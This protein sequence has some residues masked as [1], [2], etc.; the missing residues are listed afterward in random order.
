MWKNDQ[1]AQLI[2]NYMK[3]VFLLII[4]LTFFNNMATCTADVAQV[5]D[6]I[7]VWGSGWANLTYIETQ[8][9]N[10]S[11]LTHA[12]TVFL[13]G[14]NIYVNG[15]STILYINDSD[16]TWL[17]LNCTSGDVSNFRVDGYFEMNSSKIT[18]WD[19]TISAVVDHTSTTM[20]VPR[21]VIR[22]GDETHNCHVNI[23][24]S[25]ISYCGYNLS[26]STWGVYF[27]Q[28]MDGTIE[29]TILS[30]LYSICFRR[31]DNNIIN[32][33]KIYNNSFYGLYIDDY[34]DNDIIKNCEI[35]NNNYLAKLEYVYGGGGIH[36][37]GQPNNDLVF[38][39]I[40]LHDGYGG[41]FCLQSGERNII[42]NSKMYNFTVGGSYVRG[43]ELNGVKNSTV[44]NNTVYN[45]GAYALYDVYDNCNIFKNNTVYNS[46][47]GIRIYHNEDISVG[48]VYE[49]I[50]YDN[51]YHFSF[52]HSTTY[53]SV[54]DNNTISGTANDQDIYVY[55][56]TKCTLQDTNNYDNDLYIR[57]RHAAGSLFINYTNNKIM[58]N[59]T[60]TNPQNINHKY[61]TDHSSIFLNN[62]IDNT[63]VYVYLYNGTLTAQTT[64]VT[65]LSVNE[66]NETLGY[67][68]YNVT[69]DS[70]NA[71][72]ICT[73]TADVAN[74]TDNY[75]CY[76][77]G[78]WVK[79]VIAV[80]GVASWTY[81]GGFSEHD[82]KIKWN[83]TYLPSSSPVITL[84]SQT[85][86]SIYQNMTCDL[87]ISFGI[88]HD[89]AG[90]NNTSV[91]FIFRNYDHTLNDA[92]H[93]IRVPANNK[94]APW[95]YD[96]QI[97]RGNN[98]NESLNFENN[99][100]I[101]GGNIYSWSGLDENSTRLT[102][103]PINSTYTIVN[104]NGTVHDLAMEQMWYLDR[105]SMIE[106][107]KTK[108]AIHKNQDVL[109][110]FWDAE[111]FKGNY[112]FIGAGYTD[113]SLG[114]SI[115]TD[116][117]PIQYYKLNSSYDPLGGT[118]PLDS[119]YIVY[120]GALNASGWVDHVYSP[121]PNTNYVRGMIN[122]SYIHT[123][124]NT[125]EIE[126]LYFTSNTPSSKPYYINI[127]N[128]V[129]GTNRTFAE[130]NVLWIG[131]SAPYTPHPYTPNCWFAFIYNNTSFD[132]KL[133]AADNND[134]WGNSSLE[135]N[136]IE[137]GLF[138]PTTPDIDHFFF[139][140]IKIYTIN[141]T[142]YGIF[143][144]VCAL[145]S[146]PDGG[147]VNHN[148]TLH[149]ANQTFVS[150]INNTFVNGDTFTNVSFDSSSYYSD[151]EKYQMRIRATDNEGEISESWT[152]CNFSLN[153]IT[154]SPINLRQTHT[155]YW[156]NWTW[157]EGT[158]GNYNVDSYNVSINGS[159]H[160][161]TTAL[162]YNHTDLNLTE[163]STIIIYGFND[164]SNLSINY[165]SGIYTFEDRVDNPPIALSLY[166][167]IIV[168]GLIFTGMTFVTNID[169][170]I[171]AAT[172]LIAGIIFI[173][174]GTTMFTTDI[175]TYHNANTY[176]VN[177]GWIGT[178]LI[179]I[180]AVMCL[181]TILI[182]YQIFASEKIDFDYKG[183]G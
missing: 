177:I 172:S 65:I 151:T 134:S 96:G 129:S 23:S 92:N 138:P 136:M 173:L 169:H 69:V 146:D 176:L 162:Y 181:F 74:I 179:L 141:G 161:I 112:N 20:H 71:T 94:C 5:G 98:R 154:N 110:K 107:T 153:I 163:N 104:I 103:V 126:Y 149:Y 108:L 85:P 14:A 62:T 90:L 9:S 36:T 155:D 88:S 47:F 102:I 54:V 143:D 78:T 60:P 15:T 55:D 157:D 87:N 118:A 99:D 79:N 77:D 68:S 28:W 158:D 182:I 117:H 39:N 16:C 83:S 152:C 34:N 130:T 115:P 76:V 124:M 86:S 175:N 64:N 80:A 150:I 26:E 24:K 140:N 168:V 144:V 32:Y 128:A 46:G 7:Y 72:E 147:N 1:P 18:S 29:D 30:Y 120:M 43:L 57:L 67:E 81:A 41:A 156:V 49:N 114:A 121:S 111:I 73:F 51:D 11:A 125:T 170:V 12:G 63:Y 22:F 180:G 21:S 100:T 45:I 164:S 82:L 31:C 93:S 105:T 145:G 25:N 109:I 159:W 37:E 4:L 123:L 116:R 178:L 142:Y 84:L 97:I 27:Y 19:T 167:T 133:Y 113:T 101:T 137:S 95:E 33:T 10:V 91:S 42:K 119:P 3:N 61:Y 89:I 106:S 56:A 17:K 166:L 44:E 139:D 52:Y 50:F 160:N 53:N 131:D 35:Y 8:V 135:S 165:V 40:T 132:Y 13:A 122:N 38:D 6:T 66:W 59:G 70:S 2:H 174:S 148:L 171:K 75:G 48:T 127:T 183:H 58:M